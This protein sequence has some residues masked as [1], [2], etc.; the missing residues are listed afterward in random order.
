MLPGRC[1]KK[2]EKT[3]N[4]DSGVSLDVVLDAPGGQ[5][6]GRLHEQYAAAVEDQRADDVHPEEEGQIRCKSCAVDAGDGQ[7]GKAH[8]VQHLGGV[9]VQDD[10]D[11][12]HHAQRQQ[13]A[14]H[15]AQ[16]R[17]Q[18]TDGQHRQHREHHAHEAAQL[19]ADKA[20]FDVALHRKEHDVAQKDEPAVL[21]LDGVEKGVGD[22]DPRHHHQAEVEQETL[23]HSFVHGKTHFPEAAFISGVQCL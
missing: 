5:I 23:G 2:E 10:E 22:Q 11:E 3:R 12:E 17:R 21:K 15:P 6:T 8:I 14:Q 13:Q 9:G 19:H 7:V 20:V 1:E 18:R 16:N 4:S